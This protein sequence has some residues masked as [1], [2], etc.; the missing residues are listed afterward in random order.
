MAIQKKGGKRKQKF[1]ALRQ[2]L[3][4][5]ILFDASL[6]APP[7]DLGIPTEAVHHH[8]SHHGEN[9]H[10]DAST[11]KQA[12]QTPQDA[13]PANAPANNPTQTATS[14]S[15]APVQDVSKT[16]SD[17]RSGNTDNSVPL[18]PLAVSLPPVE[19]VFIDSKVIDPQSLLQGVS[20]T[21]EIHF[22]DASQDGIAQID[23]VIKAEKAPIS[24]VIILSHGDSGSLDLGNAT[25]NEQTLSDQYASE[26]NSWQSHL[27][28]NASV[29]LYGCDVAKGGLGQ[30]FV[31]DLSQDIG[32]SVAASTDYTGSALL[33]G[34]WTLEFQTGTIGASITDVL[35]SQSLENYNYLLGQPVVDFLK[36][37]F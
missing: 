21:A 1:T 34:N 9:T 23:A 37:V 22:L 31:T 24:A 33:A 27:T 25:L 29:L 11:A 3:E 10:T 8:H 32:V 19:L 28:P 7:H 26:I 14:S 30:Q 15:T 16:A 5:R 35:S 18:Q 20:S 6:A 12:P 4:P 36:N 13:P 2:A 17:T